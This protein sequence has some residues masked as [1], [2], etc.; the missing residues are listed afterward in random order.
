[1]VPLNFIL[2]DVFFPYIF[3]N[4]E[5]NVYGEKYT[6]CKKF[7]QTVSVLKLIPL[8]IV[9]KQNVSQVFSKLIYWLMR[10][11]ILHPGPSQIDPPIKG[12]LFQ[13]FST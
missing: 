12:L 8:F 7:K 9:H 11:N 6:V 4:S 2:I 3:C 1:M 13:I 5:I 10:K